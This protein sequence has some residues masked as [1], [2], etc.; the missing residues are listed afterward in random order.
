MEGPGADENK[1]TLKGTDV[2][3]DAYFYDPVEVW[4]RG[5]EESHPTQL[6]VGHPGSQNWVMVFSITP[7]L[8][9]SLL[10]SALS[11]SLPSS[12]LR[13]ALHHTRTVLLMN[14]CQV[15]GADKLSIQRNKSYKRGE[16]QNKIKI[17]G[18][19]LSER[20]HGPGTFQRHFGKGNLMC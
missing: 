5:S 14:T 11:E 10:P 1:G 17:V 8:L 18:G 19:V 2:K 4:L 7:T 6:A 16:E 13:L 9:R 15:L 20:H 12:S 3:S